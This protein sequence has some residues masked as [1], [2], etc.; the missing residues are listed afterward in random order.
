M[1]ERDYPGLLWRLLL[2]PIKL[3]VAAWWMFLLALFV[4]A[5]LGLVFGLVF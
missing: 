1:N 4:F 3:A 5:G 2:P